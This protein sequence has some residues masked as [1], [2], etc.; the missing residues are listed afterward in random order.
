LCRITTGKP[1]ARP[2]GRPFPKG[3]S[4]NPGGRP[5]QGPDRRKI[6]ADARLLARSH[7]VGAVENLVAIMNDQAAPHRA[8]IIAANAIL[9]RG[10]GR[11][12]MSLEVYEAET[13]PEEHAEAAREFIASRLAELGDRIRA[14]ND[15]PKLN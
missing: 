3:V 9:D 1:M 8:R 6:E 10:W 15:P 7:G 13:K 4:G 14:Q 2:R 11:P 12:P 5:A